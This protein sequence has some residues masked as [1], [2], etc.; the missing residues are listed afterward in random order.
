MP[1]CAAAAASNDRAT[2]KIPTG[3]ER[4]Y[5]DGKFWAHPDYC[6]AFGKDL[7][8][9]APLEP[10]EYRAMNAYGK[11]IIKAAESRSCA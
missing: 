5:A 6:E 11:A 7:V 1:S 4:L 3:T 10:A 2:N 9:G 8:T